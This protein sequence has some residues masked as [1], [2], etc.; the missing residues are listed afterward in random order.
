[1][2]KHTQAICRRIVWVCLTILWDWRLKGWFE[3]FKWKFLSKKILK[4]RVGWLFEK[5]EL[6][7]FIA[8][9]TMLYFKNCIQNCQNRHNTAWKT[10]ASSVSILMWLEKKRSFLIFVVCP[11]ATC[12]KN[13]SG[14][15]RCFPSTER[16][17]LTFKQ[18]HVTAGICYFTN[19][20]Q[21]S[22]P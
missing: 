4:Y 19:I 8:T 14:K 10:F 21:G 7:I 9:I 12:I 11:A 22:I 17:L 3:N 6:W 20:S 15:F 5:V 16:S 1:M 13:H 2:V 18:L